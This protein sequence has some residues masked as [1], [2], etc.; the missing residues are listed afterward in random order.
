MKDP[1]SLAALDVAERFANG[2]A[3]KE[4]LAAASDA[5]EAAE[6]AR[7]ATRVAAWAAARAADRAAAWAAARAAAEAAWSAAIAKQGQKLREICL[8]IEA[9]EVA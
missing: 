5:A 9:R 4:E 3:T 7:A 8:E 6:A 1:R 2:E